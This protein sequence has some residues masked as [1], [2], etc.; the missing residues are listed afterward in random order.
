MRRMDRWIR[1]GRYAA[2][3]ALARLP[4]ANVRPARLVLRLSPLSTVDWDEVVSSAVQWLGPIPVK[5]IAVDADP[6]DALSALRTAFRLGCRTSLEVGVHPIADAEALVRTGLTA[7][8]II[9]RSEAL[10]SFVAARTSALDVESALVWGTDPA[11]ADFLRWARVAQADGFRVLAPYR[12]VGVPDPS[13]LEALEAERP[14]YRTSR[15]VVAELRAMSNA[16][17]GEPGFPSHA[18]CPIGGLRIEV[19]G[20]GTVVSCPFKPPVG[21]FDGDL[22]ATWLAG[23]AHLDA[24]A[25]CPRACAHPELSPHLRR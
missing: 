17:D 15:A 23:R 25:R 5:A 21:V 19:G 14:F 9:G 18:R 24:I 13:P 22:R 1:E 11:V 16:A 2:R 8:R 3:S 6:M 7:V 20:D 4:I 12:A 10:A